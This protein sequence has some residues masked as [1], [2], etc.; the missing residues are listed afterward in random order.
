PPAQYTG[1][2]RP[3]P[4]SPSASAKVITLPTGTSRPIPR[5]TRAKARAARSGSTGSG[6]AENGGADE[7]GHAMGEHPLLVLPVL[8]DAAQCHRHR[9]LV[10]RGPSE[11]GERHGPVDRLGHPG[12]F[13]QPQASH[14]P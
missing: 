12:R 8:E 2:R 10:K 6:T 11:S 5:N 14:R 9:R 1:S 3:I 4:T 7:V 13:V